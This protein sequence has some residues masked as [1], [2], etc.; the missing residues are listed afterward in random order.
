MSSQ[1]ATVANIPVDILLEIFEIVVICAFYDNDPNTNLIP[2]QLARVCRFWRA[3]AFSSSKLWSFYHLS[4]HSRRATVCRNLERA[5]HSPLHV[6]ISGPRVIGQSPGPLVVL[7]YDISLHAD[8][9]VELHVVNILPPLMEEVLSAFNSP[10]PRLQRISVQAGAITDHRALFLGWMPMLK[11]VRISVVRMPWLPYANLRHLE[12]EYQVPPPL[13]MLYR[14]LETSLQI[15]VLS[16]TFDGHSSVTTLRSPRRFKLGNLR[17]LALGDYDSHSLYAL[18]LLSSLD[19]PA[20]TRVSILLPVHHRH[21]LQVSDI[22]PSLQ[23]VATR[24]DKLYLQYISAANISS[25]VT[26]A[27]DSTISLQWTWEGMLDDPACLK[28]MGIVAV[29]LPN[30]RSLAVQLFSFDDSRVP[31]ASILKHVP[32]LKHLQVDFRSS[33]DTAARQFLDGLIDDSSGTINVPKLAHFEILRFTDREDDI[34][35]ALLQILATRKEMGVPVHC[36]EVTLR[37]PLRPTLGVAMR[38]T[39][40]EV[41]L[42]SRPTTS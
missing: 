36:L 9:L 34:W 23:A 24:V 11:D 4:A 2:T 21:G 19:F 18:S 38:S 8:R 17:E 33:H 27:A 1:L 12:I 3:L 40:E 13:E 29:Q 25:V 39:I 6:K 31:W 32:S 28:H 42:H 37:Q 10:A 35:P 5:R 7:A 14:T 20:S 30:I 26:K 15:E 16:L 41:I 22:C